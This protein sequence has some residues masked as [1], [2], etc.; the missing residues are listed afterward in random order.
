MI[1]G[2]QG[3]TIIHPMWNTTKAVVMAP[4]LPEGGSSNVCKVATSASDDILFSAGSLGCVLYYDPLKY[5]FF[6]FKIMF[7]FLNYVY[8]FML[9]SLVLVC[10]LGPHIEDVMGL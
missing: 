3:K 2:G 9:I 4:N 10:L 6:M 5:V 1:T 8:I 7:T